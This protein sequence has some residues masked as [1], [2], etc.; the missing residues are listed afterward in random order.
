VPRTYGLP[1]R[2][3]FLPNQL[4]AH[5]NHIC[6]VRALKILKEEKCEV[7]VAA[8]GNPLDMR[9]SAYFDALME[10]VRAA[11]LKENFRFLGIV[12]YE[13]VLALM[14]SAAALVNPSRCEGWSTT[15]EE[16]K[17][18]G[19]PMILSSLPVHREQ[20]GD[21][22]LY[23][24]P[25]SPQELA[26]HLRVFQVPTRERRTAVAAQARADSALRLAQF[27]AAFR[28]IVKESLQEDPHGMRAS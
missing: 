24:S 26:T 7:V 17:S 28:D 27:A 9:H 14:Q 22:A 16:A 23:F 2:F 20:A 3:F 25:D 8:T 5:K 21:G 4:W 15:V 13:H 6:V 1:E 11:D 18:S 12:P 19:A 10:E